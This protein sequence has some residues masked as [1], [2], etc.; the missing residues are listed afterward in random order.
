MKPDFERIKATTD[1]VR[2]I[3]GYGVAL[4]K[5]GQDHV[6]L[7]P[8][9]PDKKPSLH[10][11]Q[12]KGLFHCPACGAAGNVV[13]FVARREGITDREAALKLLGALPGVQ[14]ASDLPSP[15]PACDPALHPELFQSLIDYYHKC[16][17][18]RGRPGL[19]YLKSRGLADVEMLT[20]F[21]IGYVDGGV[22]KK[23]SPAQIKAARAIGLFNDK[24][25]ERYYGRI[26]VPIFDEHQRPVGLYGRDIT[27][28]S[29]AAHLY[30]AGE[31]RA[32][33]NA[34]AAAAYPDELIAAESILDA[35][36]IFAAG[37]KNVV[38][39]YG[40]NGW[41]P[42]HDA[43][44][45]KHSV[46]KIVFAL[47]NDEAG[48]R[49]TGELAA[50]LDAKGIRC[51]H[52]KWPEHV[53]D[54]ND[55]FQYH[56][57]TG[58]KGTPETFASLLA[59][60]PRIGFTKGSTAKLTLAEH[61]DEHALFQNGS[62]SY[63][64][65]SLSSNGALKVVL[66]A[67]KEGPCGSHQHVD[68]LDLY[69]SKARKAFAGIAATRLSVEPEKIEG[70]LLAL[71]E[72]LETLQAETAR[73]TASPQAAPIM[74]EI[75]R[76]EALALLRSPDLL[77]RI[78]AD[79][80][81][82]GYVGE[83]RNKKLAYLIGT[84]RRLPK[85]LSAIFRA[86]SGCGKSFLMECVADL[87]PPEDVHYFSR[88]TP[89]A[90]YY[91]EPDA[92][93]HKL[94]IVDE[95]DGSEEAEYPIRTLQT[96]KVLK[97]AVPIKDPSSGKIKTAV[98]EIHGPIAYMES[99][100]DQRI[101]P[102]NANRCFELY[103]DE[104]EAQTRAIFAAQ[105]RARSLEGWRH[106]R[107][108][109]A[110]MRVHHNAQR[111]LR[112][113]KVIIPYVELIEFPLAWLRGRRDHDRFLSLIEGVAFLHQHQRQRDVASSTRCRAEGEE[114]LPEYIEASMEDY[115]IAY[116]LA[117][118]VF[119]D[120]A[121]D[122]PKPARDFLAQVEAVVAAE[123]GRQKGRVEEV[124]FTRRMIREATKLPDHIIK[125]HMREIEDLEYVQVQRA[126]SGGSFRYRLLP[127]KKTPAVLDGLLDPDALARKAEQA[128]QKRKSAKNAVKP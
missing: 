54:A 63:R 91:L 103:L 76:T 37:R 5:T 61:S 90:L 59:A 39:A 31:H 53:K 115:A 113:L 108:K 8:F 77:E 21:K 50:K 80:E 69:G 75:E 83:P 121:D 35:L 118:Q 47:D 1:I 36:A 11:T 16:L 42:H 58:F 30:L 10:V 82:A 97:L 22:K 99:T 48:E 43:L 95:R 123:T 9:H 120:S 71:V 100:T 125:R 66:T 2:V 34:E 26:V 25:N 18:G 109:A 56:Q 73:E 24:G 117:H 32:V 86:Q 51:H 4:K 92:L 46:R 55:Y 124:W 96:R 78:A 64:V 112:S 106:E 68:H 116:D 107:S 44:L 88:L 102:E 87:M 74:S 28:R 79:I 72:H 62:V 38:A 14:R 85:P 126:P 33:W 114:E 17:V 3:E 12:A 110:V 6:G 111:L 29:E 81:L 41:T 20:H 23:L 7:C 45:E 105:R 65:K 52:L 70:D 67:K 98:L 94:L 127:Q 13:Q 19:D 40:V 128:G 104:S 49:V 57:E 60:A 84:S 101:N 122:L 119:A 27:G 89:Q 93:T 15:A